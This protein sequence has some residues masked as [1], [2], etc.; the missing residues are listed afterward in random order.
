MSIRTRGGIALKEEEK[1]KIGI[2][3]TGK[4]GAAIATRLLNV[5]H[6]VRVWNR[7]ADKTRPLEEAG[8]KIAATPAQLASSCQLV[9]TILTD[10]AAI[11]AVYEGPEGLLDGDVAGK[12]FIEMSTVRPDTERAL[13]GRVVNKGA[14]LIDCP[15]SGSTGPA[16]EG[17]LLG[18]VGGAANDVERARPILDQICRR[19]EHVGPVGAGS[20]MKLA[21]NLPLFVFW[22]SF[23]EAL[24][25]CRSLGLEPARIVDIFAD[26][27]GGP[28]ALRGRGPTIIAA[29]A[30][31]EISPVTSDVNSIRKDLKTMIE[32]ARALGWTLPVASRA[33]ECIDE[34]A[35]EGLGSSDCVMLPARWVQGAGRMA[36]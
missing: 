4:M 22:Q 19:V 5:G 33:L 21:I 9:I 8:A 25:L 35:H 15:V 34:A 28:N 23:G 24:S 32:E 18:F 16:R 30:G 36:E 14:A 1:L 2:A 6:D 13:A 27:T 26:S 20:S 12:L 11:K 3:G 7:T 31:K 10:A 29:L 17:R